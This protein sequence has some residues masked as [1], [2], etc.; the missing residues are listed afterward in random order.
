MAKSTI[1]SKKAFLFVP[2]DI[3][4]TPQRAKNSELRP[5]LASFPDI[6]RDSLDSMDYILCVY[7]M[8]EKHKKTSSFFYPYLETINECD[9][10]LDWD[11]DDLQELQD[12][13]LSI[14]AKKSLKAMTNYYEILKPVFL[15]F[16]DCFPEDPY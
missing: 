8:F 13:F 6:F 2:H 15:K 12:P 5:V 16:P 14:K 9:L 4:I 11:E 7:L 10:L 1:S 3:I